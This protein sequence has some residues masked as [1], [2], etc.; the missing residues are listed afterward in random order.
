MKKYEE[1]FDKV[2]Q[3]IIE[4]LE[5]ADNWRKP[6]ATIA[7]GSVPHNA[8]TGRP[9]S[10]INFLNLAYASEKWGNQG[11]LTYKQATALGGK[12]PSKDDPNGGCE[13]VW[14]MSV[15]KYKEKSTGEDKKGF[16]NKCFAIWNVAQIEGLEGIKEYAKPLAGKGSANLLAESLGVNLQ[17]GGDKACFVPSLDQIRM[18]SAEAFKDQANHDATLL[19]ELTHWTGHKDRLNRLKACQGFG[20]ESYAFEELVAELGSAMGGALLGIPYEG[21]QHESYIKGWLKVLKQDPKHL[22]KAASLASKAVNYM[23]ENGAVE[24]IEKSANQAA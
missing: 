17:Y 12:V 18:P 19:H 3:R 22:V 4:N 23:V 5:S 24:E 11:W 16:I 10:G 2:A 20:S 21:L 6:W 9:Y 13:Y 14:F 7:D 8:S 1:L 15:S